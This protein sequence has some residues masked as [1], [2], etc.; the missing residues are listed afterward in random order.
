[1]GEGRGA[2]E[3]DLLTALGAEAR[4]SRSVPAASISESCSQ[5]LRSP[6]SATPSLQVIAGSE[7][8]RVW[9]VPARPPGRESLL[10]AESAFAGHFL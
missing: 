3:V 7:A 8:E 5:I 4:F 10:A 9:A 1:M 6:W 2:R